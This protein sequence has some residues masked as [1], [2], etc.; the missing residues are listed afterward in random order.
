M[1]KYT[2]RWPTAPRITYWFSPNWFHDA[3]W[4]KKKVLSLIKRNWKAVK[5]GDL[6]RKREQSEEKR[7]AKLDKD[8]WL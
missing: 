2:R 4:P 1:S 7:K 6:A 8:Y 5:K 3:G